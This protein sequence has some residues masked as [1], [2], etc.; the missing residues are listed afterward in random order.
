M[1][2]GKHVF[3]W[4]C[5]GQ[6]ARSALPPGAFICRQTRGAED[7]RRLYFDAEAGKIKTDQDRFP[8][9]IQQMV[10]L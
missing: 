7:R 5:A 6:D 3:R 10:A 4:A 9:T 1:K 8:P 2:T